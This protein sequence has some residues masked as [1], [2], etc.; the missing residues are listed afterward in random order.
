[1]AGE[2]DG[3][4]HGRGIIPFRGAAASLPLL[5]AVMVLSRILLH[6]ALHAPPVGRDLADAVLRGVRRAQLS[7]KRL[8]ADQLQFGHV[9]PRTA[10]RPHLHLAEPLEVVKVVPSLRDTGAESEHAMVRAQHRART[11]AVVPHE[12]LRH[13]GGPV[14][15]VG[16]EEAAPRVVVGDVTAVANGWCVWKMAAA[17]L[18]SALCMARCEK[19]PVLSGQ[20][21][22]TRTFPSKST[23]WMSDALAWDQ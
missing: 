3:L 15:R 23:T 14:G 21:E 18:P 6:Q 17:P 2:G 5:A 1:M 11:S 20:P 16:V 19:N 10:Q 22:P 8:V 4:E 7:L 12:A 9:A 13:G